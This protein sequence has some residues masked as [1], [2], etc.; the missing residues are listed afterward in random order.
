MVAAF[1]KH[2]RCIFLVTS[3]LL[4]ACLDSELAD[5]IYVDGDGVFLQ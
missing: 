2:P 1:A 5:S 3:F 4:V